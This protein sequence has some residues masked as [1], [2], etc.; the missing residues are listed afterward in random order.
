MKKR[1]ETYFE[2][3]S[4]R[5]NS[6]K[7]ARVELAKKSLIDAWNVWARSLLVLFASML[8]IVESLLFVIILGSFNS[9]EF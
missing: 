8:S 4:L 1:T 2:F 3:T 6:L 9:R 7:C 5:Y